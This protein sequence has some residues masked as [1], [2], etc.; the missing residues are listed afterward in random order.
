MW[1][2]KTI[3]RYCIYIY[4]PAPQGYN[5]CIPGNFRGMYISRLAV[6]S[7]FPGSNFADEGIYIYPAIE[8]SI[9]HTHVRTP[10]ML[11]DKFSQIKFSLW[12]FQPRNP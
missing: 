10:G 5:Y 3:A 12:L 7:I 1:Q 6:K 11:D 9:S 2:P 4:L 8:I